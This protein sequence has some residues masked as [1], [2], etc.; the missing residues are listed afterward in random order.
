MNSYTTIDVDTPVPDRDRLSASDL[1]RRKRA[2]NTIL[3]SAVVSESK[4]A[5]QRLRK[6]EA[7][8]G[9]HRLC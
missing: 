1:A 2:K 5:V 3:Q 4:R 8:R 7:A 6:A 9:R